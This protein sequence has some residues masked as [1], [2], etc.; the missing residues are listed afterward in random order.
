MIRGTWITRLFATAVAAVA[1]AA[2]AGAGLLPVS[3]TVTP[4]SG[5]F[6]WTYAIVLP[7]D[8]KLQAGN[9]FTIYDF[10]GYKAGGDASPGSR[11]G[12]DTSSS[13][14][15]SFSAQQ[16]G[17]T[18]D[19]L[20]PNDDKAVINLTWT[21]KGPT[22]PSGQIGLGNFWAMSQFGTSMGASFTAMTA[23]TS[24][25]L[26]DSNITETEV[27]TITSAP[28]PSTVPEPMTL[29]LAGLG[30]P[31]DQENAQWTDGS[32]GRAKAC[33]SGLV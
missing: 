11:P 30:L 1:S 23:R 26:V 8:M 17:P 29:L 20:R 18:P 19:H 28:P 32:C 4:D 10:N 12:C 9:Y 13:S 16:N 7:T 5:N 33:C 3:V 14:D 27:P 22:I 21:Y 15:W 24:D 25:G 6:R 2:T 31:L